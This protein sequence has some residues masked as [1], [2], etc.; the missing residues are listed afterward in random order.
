MQ[1]AAQGMGGWNVSGQVGGLGGGA[2]SVC[3]GAG[4]AER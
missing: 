2:V 1:K 3:V 4:A